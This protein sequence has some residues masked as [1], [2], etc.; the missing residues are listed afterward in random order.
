LT[1]ENVAA[2]PATM[3]NLGTEAIDDA[4]YAMTE[5]WVDYHDSIASAESEAFEALSDSLQ[6]ADMTPEELGRVSEDVL[7]R[8]AS[9]VFM[10]GREAER[11]AAAKAR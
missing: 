5:R 10:A 1:T 3:S 6:L 9:F 7:M 4:V 11:A 8:F 2:T